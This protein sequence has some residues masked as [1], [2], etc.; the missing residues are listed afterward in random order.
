M[1]VRIIIVLHWYCWCCILV[2][3]QPRVHHRAPPPPATLVCV[4]APSCNECLNS[5]SRHGSRR[6]AERKSEEEAA[7]RSKKKKSS[8]TSRPANSETGCGS[9]DWL[10]RTTVELEMQQQQQWQWQWQRC[11]CIALFFRLSSLF[12]GCNSRSSHRNPMQ[13]MCV[14]KGSR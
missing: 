7:R 1:H 3:R 4:R 10:Q 6:T 14:L 2:L 12:F 11:H 5:S 13:L 8:T 9:R